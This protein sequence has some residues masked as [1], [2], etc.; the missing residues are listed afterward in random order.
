MRFEGTMLDAA[1]AAVMKTL[2][3]INSHFPLKH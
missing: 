3:A 1:A 2:Q